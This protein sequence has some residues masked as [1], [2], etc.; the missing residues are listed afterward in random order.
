MFAGVPLSQEPG[1]IPS[2]PLTWIEVEI[3]VL[4][5]LAATAQG[6]VF[7]SFFYEFSSYSVLQLVSDQSQLFV[8][9]QLYGLTYIGKQTSMAGLMGRG[10][11]RFLF[12]SSDFL[13]DVLLLTV[14]C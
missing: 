7:V 11:S 4:L 9:G 8:Y 10:G 2:D 1:L 3:F 12:V 5:E 14:F 13:K 6:S